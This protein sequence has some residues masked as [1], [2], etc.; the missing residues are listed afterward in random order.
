MTPH[1]VTSSYWATP[2][3]LRAMLTD[4][5]WGRKVVKFEEGWIDTSRAECQIGWESV[6]LQCGE[7]INVGNLKEYPN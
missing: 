5:D 4:P 3:Q 7:I 6:Y 1:D 2:D